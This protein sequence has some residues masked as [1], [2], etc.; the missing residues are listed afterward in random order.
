MNA[1]WRIPPANSFSR[2]VAGSVERRKLKVSSDGPVCDSDPYPHIPA[3]E[4]LMRCTGAKCYRDPGF[5]RLVCRL[6]FSSPL[7]HDGVTIYAFMNLGDGE[8][9]PGRRSRY[10]KAWTMANAAPPRRGQTMTSRVFL[11]KWFK[12]SVADVSHAADQKPNH[13]AAIYS[14]VREILELD[15]A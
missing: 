6:A 7:V 5:H 15:H 1:A 2:S 11:G 10:W 14:T 9:C 12:V 13:A 3:S 8:R 4:Y